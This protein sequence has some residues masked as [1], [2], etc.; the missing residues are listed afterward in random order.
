MQA[1]GCRF[2]LGGGI[3]SLRHQSQGFERLV[4]FL[5]SRPELR[6]NFCPVYGFY[7]GN[8]ARITA[9]SGHNRGNEDAGKKYEPVSMTRRHG[10]MRRVKIR[11]IGANKKARA[12]PAAVGGVVE[13]M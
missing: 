10:F 9:R 13:A 5:W 8:D 6:L 12:E 11:L 7:A 4:R 1:G 2:L 3:V